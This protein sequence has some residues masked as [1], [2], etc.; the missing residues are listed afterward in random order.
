M[1][2]AWMDLVA[3]GA[4]NACASVLAEAKMALLARTLVTLHAGLGDLVGREIGHADDRTLCAAGLKVFGHVTVALL[5]GLAAAPTLGMSG[6]APAVDL[7]F[8]ALGACFRAGERFRAYRRG[9]G[10]FG[11][12]RCSLRLRNTAYGWA[13]SFERADQKDDCRRS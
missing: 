9:R 8:V 11:S 13:R 1:F 7:V 2:G 10:G 4:G 6:S 3:G 5:A 12:M